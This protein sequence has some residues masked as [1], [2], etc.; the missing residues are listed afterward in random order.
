[1]IDG[2]DREWMPIRLKLIQDALVEKISDRTYHGDPWS[3][4]IHTMSPR[5]ATWMIH[6]LA[7]AGYGNELAGWLESFIHN[8]IPIPT[9]QLIQWIRCVPLEAIQGPYRSMFEGLLAHP[10][11]RIRHAVVLALRHHQ[12]QE[13]STTIAR[14][15]ERESDRIVYYS[16]WRLLGDWENEDSLTSMLQ[17]KSVGIRRG[18]LLALLESGQVRQSAIESMKSDPDPSISALA[19]KWL[20]GADA[21]IIRGNP[22]PES[23]Q[24]ARHT[25]P[26][27]DPLT[28]PGTRLFSGNPKSRWVTA[29][30]GEKT[31]SDRSYS[32]RRLPDE[33]MG[34]A[35]LQTPNEDDRNPEFGMEI[36]FDVP[37]RLFVAHDIR[38]PPAHQPAWLSAFQP[39]PGLIHTEDSQF[40]LFIMNA[41]PGTIQLGA[42]T[43]IPTPPYGMANYFVLVGNSLPSNVSAQTK[44]TKLED[45]LPLLPQA[46]ILRGR[47]LFLSTNGAACAA[48]HRMDGIGNSYAPDLSGIG[49][50][51][52]ADFIIS[53]ILDPDLAITEGYRQVA[54]STVDG[55]VFSGMILNETSRQM[56]L[57][58]LN[59]EVVTVP[60]DQIESRETL[61]HS[62]MPGHFSMLLD[63]A[64][65]ADITR[66]LTTQTRIQ[67]TPSH[68][69]QKPPD[70]ITRFWK[71]DL[72]DDQLTIT[73]RDQ[74]IATYWT[75]HP[76]MS[77]PG[78][79]NI[80]SLSGAPITRPFPAGPEADHQFM[81]PGI[82]LSFGWLDGHDFW[83][84]KARVEHLRFI[85]PPSVQAETLTFSVKN[86][87][88]STDGQST[89]C[90]EISQ[91]SF[92]PRPF[93]IVLDW[94][95]SFYSDDHDFTFGDQEESGL[96]IRMAPD[97]I[98]RAGAGSIRASHGGLNESG[99]WGKSFEWI[100]Y[101]GIRNGQR[102]GIA[103]Q[104]DF[105]DGRTCWAHSRDYGVLVAN[106]F[107]R[108][109]RSQRDP[110]HPTTIPRFQP[111]V[112]AYRLVLFELGSD[113]AFTPDLFSDHSSE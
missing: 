81:H 37:S 91:F 87:Y 59:G 101:S 55:G 53:S 112:M 80:H 94:Q 70:N 35:L 23:P 39:Y 1:M 83:R 95:S 5:G 26:A 66:W 82:S 58:L 92:H 32:I 113:R 97:L 56:D 34:M 71:F 38:I 105:P 68:N 108:Q 63:A 75:S 85:Q 102:L 31:Y 99:T 28:P 51:A 61:N 19:R 93:G 42:N 77:R 88:V 8:K 3:E 111:F 14:A 36:R 15:L 6:A 2:L 4:R 98:V 21:Q 41:D 89:V 76:Q 57:V 107:P 109:S 30:P 86:R 24:L 9:G 17:S 18:A 110:I 11:P 54:I 100:E 69:Q 65:V 73:W 74:D 22:L 84:M 90:Y 45:V 47:D 44:M 104:P 29:R 46:D 13:W 10:E 78:F 43:K 79:S 67:P 103:I 106:P 62:A 49:S 60:R 7:R 16:L 40:Q 48:C 50:R 12:P 72:Q 52:S 20:N 25:V 33:F 27:P 64:Q 96:A